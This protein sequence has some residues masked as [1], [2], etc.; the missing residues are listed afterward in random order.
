MKQALIV[1]AVAA[2]ATPAFAASLAQAEVANGPWYHGVYTQGV[3]GDVSTTIEFREG[4]VGGNGDRGTVVASFPLTFDLPVPGT[5]TIEV[6]LETEDHFQLTTTD[7]GYSY[8]YDTGLTDPNDPNNSPIVQGVQGGGPVLAMGGTGN[9]NQFYG[10][11]AGNGVADW[12]GWYW[13]GG[14]PYAG[15]YMKLWDVAGNV[16]Y[17]NTAPV[18]PNGTRY[19]SR[20][21]L[22]WGDLGSTPVTIGKFEVGFVTEVPEPASFALIGFAALLLRRR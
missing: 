15:F 1:L 4:T 17:D 16:V 14:D 9:E 2:L 8:F 10:D 5:Y 22:D 19:Y 7:F 13:F 20:P 21:A 6:P 18:D 3:R 12:D 11:A